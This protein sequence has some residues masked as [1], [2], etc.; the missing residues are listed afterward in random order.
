MKVKFLIH[1]KFKERLKEIDSPITNAFLSLKKIDNSKD[2][3]RNYINVS[4]DN[5][6]LVSFLDKRKEDLLNENLISLKSCDMIEAGDEVIID[7]FAYKNYFNHYSRTIEKGLGIIPYSYVGYNLKVK[8]LGGDQYRNVDC[9]LVSNIHTSLLNPTTPKFIVNKEILEVWEPNKRLK[10]KIG[11]LV[12]TLFPQQFTEKEIEM[13]TLAYQKQGLMECGMD[14]AFYKIYSGEDIK[15]AYHEDNYVENVAGD[16]SSSCMRYNS[17]RGYFNIYTEN[18]RQV[19]LLAIVDVNE[20]IRARCILWYPEGKEGV[21]Y[22]DR[23][24]FHTTEDRSFMEI[25]LQ[26]NGYINVFNDRNLKPVTFKLDLGFN[27]DWDYPYMDSFKYLS[28]NNTISTYEEQD[29]CLNYTDGQYEDCSEDDDDDSPWCE[30]CEENVDNVHEIVAERRVGTYACEECSRYCDDVEGYVLNDFTVYSDY[31]NCH[32]YEDNTVYSIGMDSYILEVDSIRLYDDSYTHN[33]STTFRDVDGNWFLEHDSDF[34]KIGEI[35]YNT[36]NYNIVEDNEG[37]FQLQ[38][39]CIEIDAVYYH[40]DSM[41]IELI[42][43]EYKLK[44]HVEQ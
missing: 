22:H 20:K 43:N 17:C 6:S 1:Q 34:I 27:S 39:N 38:E 3:Y 18:T 19:E 21:K 2:N 7:K 36:D 5:K 31:D 24:Y 11:K 15:Y 35:W 44:E 23:I 26:T 29:Y 10:S 33:D 12:Q 28:C 4:F 16:L 25:Y 9:K 40:K 13:F 30:C 42:D 41:E 32:Y 8:F 14:N 37:D